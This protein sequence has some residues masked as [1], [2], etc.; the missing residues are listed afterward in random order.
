MIIPS[1]VTT[2]NESVLSKLE[3]ILKELN[4]EE[5]L[6]SLYQKVEKKFTGIDQFLYALDVLYVLDRITFDENT[7]IVK[8]VG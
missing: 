4:N 3:P 8:N 2:F 6:I 7:R 1:K 5:E